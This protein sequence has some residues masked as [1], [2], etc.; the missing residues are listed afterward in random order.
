MPDT[1]TRTPFGG[2]TPCITRWKCGELATTRRGITPSSK[3]LPSEY[4][5]ARNASSALTRWATPAS[6]TAHSSASRMRGTMS[7]GNGRSSPPMSKV[8]PWSM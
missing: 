6:I 3:T 2:T 1:C 4:T 7:S 5:S 8:T